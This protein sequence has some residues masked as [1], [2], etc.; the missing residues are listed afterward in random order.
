MNHTP[1]PLPRESVQESEEN[2]LVSYFGK[3]D[4]LEEKENKDGNYGELIED[5]KEWRKQTVTTK[6]WQELEPRRLKAV[7]ACMG[8]VDS[9][10]FLNL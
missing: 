1:S 3:K 2:S 6:R 5:Y 9:L 7:E 10:Q 4:S 8:I